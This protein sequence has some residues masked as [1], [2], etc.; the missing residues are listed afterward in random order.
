MSTLTT[1]AF[2]AIGGDTAG[3]GSFPQGAEITVVATAY[4]DY[5]FT[6]WAY[7]N[8]LEASTDASYTFTLATNTELI[9]HFRYDKAVFDLVKL[10]RVDSEGVRQQSVWVNPAHVIYVTVRADGITHVYLRDEK[11]MFVLE[12]PP[13]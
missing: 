1:S 2:P 7:I 5:A 9:A 3:D 4:P 6:Y 8:G 12:R 13:E 10:T 11:E